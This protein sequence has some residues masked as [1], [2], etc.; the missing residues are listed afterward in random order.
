MPAHPIPP[1]REHKI[2]QHGITRNDEYYWMRNREDPEVLKYLQAENQY[3]DEV[4]SHIKP[5]QEKLF[6]EMKGRIQETDSS[7]PVKKDNY[8]YY[9]RNEAGR[10]YPIFCRKKDSLDAPEEIL[11]DQNILAEG[12][13]FCSVSAFSVSPDHTKLAYSIDYEGAE[14]YTI[15]VKDLISGELFPERIKGVLGSVYYHTGVEWAMDSQTFFYLTLDEYHRAD[16]LHRHKLGTDP[17]QDT[18]VVHEKDDSYSL[19][20]SPSTP[21]AQRTSSCCTTTPR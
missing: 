20:R 13:E 17:S 15:V 7:V 6:Q 14:V 19:T 5:L 1:K 21:R 4:L 9:T 8:F 11:L 12:H 2:T 3:R 18:L 10:Q 16:K